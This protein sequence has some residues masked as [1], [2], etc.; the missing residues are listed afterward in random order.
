MFVV[1]EKKAL[2]YTVATAST[3]LSPLGEGESVE[4][5]K[6]EKVQK[7]PILSSRP[8]SI[9]TVY[10]IPALTLLNEGIKVPIKGNTFSVFY[11]IGQ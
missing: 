8:W 4:L 5:L 7:L 11:D 6:S 9:R 3:L 2:I 10:T 1:S